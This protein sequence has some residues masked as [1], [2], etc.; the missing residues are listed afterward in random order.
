MSVGSVAVAAW[1]PTSSPDDADEIGGNLPPQE[2]S[3][4]SS[5]STKEEINSSAKKRKAHRIAATS[6]ELESMLAQGDFPPGP[7]TL[8]EALA[9]ATQYLTRI[10]Q[11]QPQMY[12]RIVE[13]LLFTD[14]SSPLM[15]TADYSG[16]GGPELALDEILDA[17][18]SRGLNV[19]VR[20]FR[21]REKSKQ[22]RVVLLARPPPAGPEHVFK[23]ILDSL[24]A[25][26]QMKTLLLEHRMRVRSRKPHLTHVMNQLAL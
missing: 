7:C 12:K 25:S 14:F 24:S 5:S 19:S 18:R 3:R 20:F 4:P 8:D 17:L 10:D 23:D 16:L 2:L 6:P 26:Q 21:A 1:L 15:V 22:C 11:N 13:K 9:W